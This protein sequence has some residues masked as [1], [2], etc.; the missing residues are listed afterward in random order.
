MGRRTLINC[1][2]SNL[3]RVLGEEND[4]SGC[5]RLFI[6]NVSLPHY[7]GLKWEIVVQDAFLS[8]GVW[9]CVSEHT[10]FVLCYTGCFRASD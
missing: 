3:C 2:A 6:V 5:W 8:V 10:V 9:K 1:W 7:R 4:D